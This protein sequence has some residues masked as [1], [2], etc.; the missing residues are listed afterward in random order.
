MSDGSG[1]ELI[2]YTLGGVGVGAIVMGLVVWLVKA[3]G[4]RVVQREDDDKKQLQAKLEKL[5]ERSVEFTRVISEA[6]LN[7]KHDMQG[8]RSA[9]DQLKQQVESRAIQQDKEIAELRAEFTKL[10]EQ[11]EHRLRTDMQRLMPTGPTRKKSH[12]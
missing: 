5:E 12:A 4:G 3:L 11:T 7:I 1:G 9:M 6:L 8:M 2:G 10:L